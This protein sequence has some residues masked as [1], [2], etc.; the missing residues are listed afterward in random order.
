MTPLLVLKHPQPDVYARPSADRSKENLDRMASSREPSAKCQATW[1]MSVNAVF[2][3][4][5]DAR[6]RY[7]AKYAMRLISFSLFGASEAYFLGAEEN[8]RNWRNVYP[9]WMMRIY[10]SDRIRMEKLSQLEGYGAEIITMPQKGTYDGLGWRFLPAEDANVDA[11]ISRD[12]DALVGERERSAVDQWLS[13]G[14]LLHIIRDHPQHKALI[15]AGLWG[16][17][18]GAIP[19]ISARIEKYGRKHGF[20]DRRWDQKF[21]A[22]MVYPSLSHSLHVNSE[23]ISYEDEEAHNIP[24][25]RDEG[26]YLGLPYGRRTISRRRKKIFEERKNTGATKRPLP[27]FVRRRV[28]AL[29]S[30]Q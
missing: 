29:N 9:D 13:S 2:S 19:D 12:I 28:K 18:V 4:C 15:C 17:R 16:A 10:V 23:F 26:D 8:L 20:E 1:G 21:L 22:R 30:N 5:F 7:G 24:I 14:K 27:P 3:G 11:F 6:C 25:K